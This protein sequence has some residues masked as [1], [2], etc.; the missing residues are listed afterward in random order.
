MFEIKKKKINKFMKKDE[1]F[2]Q[3]YDTTEVTDSNRIIF[4]PS[5]FAKET[6]WYIQEIGT[7]KSLKPH[8]NQREGLDSYLF[9]IVLSGKG[10]FTYNGE[11]NY[12]NSNDI[13][14][15]DCKKKYSHRSSSTDPWE[16]I[17]VH[18][19]G[20]LIGN[21]YR[22]FFK[23]MDSIIFN[24]H[25]SLDFKNTLFQLIDLTSDKNAISELLSSNL[26]N[27]LVTQ[28]LTL[29]KVDIKDYRNISSEKTIQ[30]KQYIDK[31]FRQKLSLDNIAKEFYISKYYMSRE[32][33]KFYGI[34]IYLY[35]INKRITLAKELL[36]FSGKSIGEICQLCG[37]NDRSYFNKIFQKNEN[38][39]PSEYRKK[40]NGTL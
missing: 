5:T 21:Y 3:R 36:R 29:K 15:V 26:L 32:F 7:L 30:I 17:W 14:F 18:F 39:S 10:T 13:V 20:N 28:A 31:N 6:L 12:L 25:S 19:N 9:M 34:T 16:L 38:M 33:K 27:T 35:I 24:S 23:K 11:L 37:I 2:F 40:W 22:H 4:T 1:F 8:T